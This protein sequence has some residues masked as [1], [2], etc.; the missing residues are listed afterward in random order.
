MSGSPTAPVPPPPW[1]HR[2]AQDTRGLDP[3]AIAEPLRIPP[4]EGEHRRAAVLM[5]F[6][7]D[8]QGAQTVVL[9]QRS[10]QLRAHAG[11]VAFPGGRIDDDGDDGPVGAALRESHEEI[12][13]E[14][15]A[16]EVVGLLPELFVP[17]SR[18]AVTTVLGWAPT[19]TPLW[20]RS[21]QEVDAVA[22]VPLERLVDPAHRIVA[23]H[24]VGYAGPAFDLP[25]LYIWGF[26][27]LLLDRVLDLGGLARPWDRSR[28][29][30]LPERFG[31][32]MR[33]RPLTSA[34]SD[35]V[36]ST[37]GGTSGTGEDS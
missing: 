5:L 1:L 36:T 20:A 3:A 16:V 28:E 14:P 11:Q 23:T 7:P 19:P 6:G 10:A 27:A 33:S 34:S 21:T 37:S 8:E 9:T 15:A 22:R 4:S 18:S 17:V 26:T 2:L 12:G 29:R 31:R 35:S 13:L 32:P 25:E 30:P 24:P